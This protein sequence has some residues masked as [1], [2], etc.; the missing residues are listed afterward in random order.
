MSIKTVS[1]F[2]SIFQFESLAFLLKSQVERAISYLADYAAAGS[3]IL[4]KG[5]SWCFLS[6]SKLMIQIVGPL[7]HCHLID[8]IS[9]HYLL[10]CPLE[11]KSFTAEKVLRL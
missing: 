9:L 4:N 3:Q 6:I 2:V 10:H 8:W 5:M 1:D 7:L 11:C